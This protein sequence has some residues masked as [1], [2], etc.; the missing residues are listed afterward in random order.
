[1]SISHRISRMSI[2]RQGWRGSTY[3]VMARCASAWGLALIS[4]VNYCP[5]MRSPSIHLTRCARFGLAG[6]ACLLLNGCFLTPRLWEEP[7]PTYSTATGAL[8]APAPATADGWR[9]LA[10]AVELHADADGLLR[11]LARLPAGAQCDWIARNLANGTTVLEAE[12][13][14]GQPWS[15]LATPHDGPADG[16]W[17]ALGSYRYFPASGTTPARLVRDS[18]RLAYPLLPDEAESLLWLADARP[19]VRYQG[20]DEHQ[21]IAR[22]SIQGSNGT[23][24]VILSRRTP[25]H[26]IE[27]AGAAVATPFTLVLDGI[28]AVG[29]GIGFVFLVGLT[30]TSGGIHPGFLP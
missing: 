15:M 2:T 17:R 16:P 13:T 7:Q 9:P 12:W 11:N 1:M 25:R 21:R 24:Q 8:A 23:W 6:T 27:T 28:G 22:V 19:A 26:L 29:I 10:H 5:A 3:A 18:G 30:T 4:F 14:I 20:T